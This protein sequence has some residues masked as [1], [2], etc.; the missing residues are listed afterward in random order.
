LIPE[1]ISNLLPNQSV[2]ELINGKEWIVES[3]D[4]NKFTCLAVLRKKDNPNWGTYTLNEGS[5]P[6]FSLTPPTTEEIKVAQEAQEKMNEPKKLG[7]PN[8]FACSCGLEGKK[9]CEWILEEVK[10]LLGAT[11]KDLLTKVVYSLQSDYDAN[12]TSIPSDMW[13][14]VDTQTYDVV[15]N[16]EGSY[17]KVEPPIF[18][19]DIQCDQ[20]EYGIAATWYAYYKKFGEK[21][22]E[23]GE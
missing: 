8:Y 11:D 20:I 19:T 18:T 10:K 1:N 16:E 7:G 3:T 13:S 12:I 21:R 14:R 5:A 6:Q 22:I 9:E 23:N 2:Y 15:K 17:K 4:R